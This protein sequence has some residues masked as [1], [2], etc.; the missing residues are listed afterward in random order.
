[1]SEYRRHA[2]TVSICKYHFVWCPKYRH[3]MLS[4]ITDGLTELFH[5]TATRFGH[6]IFSL[7]IAEDHVHL[8][9]Q[10]DPSYSPAEVAKQ[11]K[12]YSGKEILER[13]PELREAYFWGSG[14]W[15]DGYY[16]G[17]TGNVSAEV[18]R[19]YIEETKH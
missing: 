3:P 13:H 11:L 5:E 8:F 19:R 4:Y 16:V 2:H 18:V 9:I 12:G 1:M 10:T 15:K 14:L 17:T 7:E 6:E